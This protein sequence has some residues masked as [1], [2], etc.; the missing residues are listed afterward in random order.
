MFLRTEKEIRNEI[1]RLQTM[2]IAELGA[3]AF[4]RASVRISTLLWVI[5]EGG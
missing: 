3:E 5:N 1:G 2:G 4:M